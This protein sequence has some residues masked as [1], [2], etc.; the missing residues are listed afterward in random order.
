MVERS[1]IVSIKK[2]KVKTGESIASLAKANSLT[3]Q[4]LAIFNWGTSV[5]EEINRFLREQVGC[6]KRTKDGHNYLF[7]SSDDPG[8]I[9]IPLPWNQSGLATNKTHVIRV[10]RQAPEASGILYFED[11]LYTLPLTPYVILDDSG[12][13]VASGKS[14]RS[15]RIQLPDQY[16]SSWTI[17]TGKLHSVVAT[18]MLPG[19]RKPLAEQEVEVVVWTQKAIIT[20]TDEKGRI[21]LQDVPEG[22]LAV[23]WNDHQAVLYVAGDVSDGRLVLKPPE[24]SGDDAEQPDDHQ[25]FAESKKKGALLRIRLPVNPADPRSGDDH[26]T[27]MS[28]P[29]GSYCEMQTAGDDITPGDTSVELIFEDLDPE[30]KYSLEI[31]TGLEGTRYFLFRNLSC[32]EFNQLGKG[33]S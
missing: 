25:A 4:Q 15:A 12:S 22:S 20:R 23:R 29:P 17:L 14:D 6:T 21:S 13:I 11:M 27:L 9:Y 5:P 2:H 30:L 32:E 33:S 16:K 7:D 10:S 28:E 31:D 19:N 3:W 24:G 26:F 1:Y 8:I 18:V